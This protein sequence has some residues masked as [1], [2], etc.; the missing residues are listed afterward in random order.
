MRRALALISG[1]KDSIYSLHLAIWQGFD[2]RALGVIIPPPDSMVVQ[3]E[4]VRFSD[5][6]ARAL[7]I[8]TLFVESGFGEHSEISAIY[9][10]LQSARLEYNVNWVIVGALSSD[11]QRIR[12]NYP[13]GDLGLKIHAPLWHLDPFTYL[14]NIVRGG[15]EFV[16]T[17]VAA[18]GL[19][20][21]W[22]GKRVDEGNVDELLSVADRY[23]FN[24]AGEGGEYESFVVKT[25]L[26]ELEIKGEINGNRFDIREV[27]VL[28]TY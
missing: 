25:P 3:H 1:G 17:R 7:N 4:N 9:S 28:D 18:A 12:F 21:S 26:Y 23:S 5:A 14:E 10:A 2:V 20:R 8:P 16:I 15:F 24:P 22:L 27:D 19:D 6:H 11:Y 13:A